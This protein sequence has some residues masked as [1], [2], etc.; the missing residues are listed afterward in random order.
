MAYDPYGYQTD[1]EE[2]PPESSA[3]NAALAGVS[4]VLCLGGALL[5][6]GL[7]TGLLIVSPPEGEN[8]WVELAG[9]WHI[10]MAPAWILVF[11]A[12]WTVGLHSLAKRWWTSA[13]PNL[14]TGGGCGCVTWVVVLFAWA[15]LSVALKG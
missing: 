5:Y 13:G 14:L 1:H 8:T 4:T 11:I 7:C 3:A 10:L 2:R 12:L 9:I 15:A 6:G